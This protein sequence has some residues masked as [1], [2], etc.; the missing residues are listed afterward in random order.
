M[1]PTN[2][3]LDDRFVVEEPIRRGG[4]GIVHRALDRLTG[5]PV[6]IKILHDPND[7]EQVARFAR[8]AS[9]IVGISH[10]AIVRGVASGRDPTGRPYLAMEWLEGEPLDV[11]LRRGPLDASDVVFLGERVATALSVV[12]AH[13][14]VH[15][16]L[17][18][19]NVMLIDGRPDLATLIDFGAA[20]QFE[21]EQAWTESG[22]LVG[23]PSYMAPEQAS[24]A[25][26]VDARADLFSLGCVLF[27]CA[28]GR[29]A[30]TG[31]HVMAILAKILVEEL[32]RL[33]ELRP[34]LPRALDA[35]VARL[36][37]KSADERPSSAEAV[38]RALAAIE[39]GDARASSRRISLLPHAT[40]SVPPPSVASAA[41][42]ASEQRL[43]GVVLVRPLD[44]SRLPAGDPSRRPASATPAPGR[45][46]QDGAA[47]LAAFR[48]SVE[49]AM[50]PTVLREAGAR[51][52]VLAN[53]TVA[54][55]F[56][57]EG[58][59]TDLVRRA[60]ASANAII[61]ASPDAVAALSF[62]RAPFGDRLATGAVI[63]RAAEL[64]SRF[65]RDATPAPSAIRI[66]ELSAALL[67][68]ERGV[69]GRP[70]DEGQEFFFVGAA[71][72]ESPIRTLLGR[73]TPF[74]GRQRELGAVLAA[75]EESA[76]ARRAMAVVLT[77]PAGI[78]K[79]RLRFEVTRVAAGGS[80][81]PTVLLGRGE[82]IG[83]GA[84]LRP[85]AQIVAAAAGIEPK[86]DLR[87]RKRAL[88]ARI[89]GVVPPGERARIGAFLGELVGASEDDTAYPPLRAARRDARWMGEQIRS[90]FIDWLAAETAARPVVLIV[91]D[92]QWADVASVQWLDEALRVLAERPFA[93]FAIGRP[94][95]HE[96]LGRP[97]IDRNLTELRLHELPAA[98][99]RTL[100]H[101]SLGE[102]LPSIEVDRLIE[103]A[104]GNAFYLE[105]LIRE[106]HEAGERGG[107]S[108]PFPATVLAMAQSR[109]ERLPPDARQ[110]LRAASVVGRSFDRG[111]LRLI[112]G[113]EFASKLDGIIDALV[114]REVLTESASRRRADDDARAGELVFRSAMLRDAAYAMLT[115]DDAR[116]AHRAMADALEQDP[117]SDPLVVAEHADLAGQPTRAI[118]SYL[119]A[120]RQALTAGDWEAAFSRAERGIALGASGE[121]L[122]ALR[123]VMA[124]VR[125]FQG[126]LDAL[127]ELAMAA[128]EDLVPGSGD[129]YQAIASM[130]VARAEQNGRHDELEWLISSLHDD[131]R[132][133]TADRLAAV[134]SAAMALMTTGQSS[135][136]LPLIEYARA[137]ADGEAGDPL[138][139]AHVS[140]VEGIAA[141]LIAG[142]LGGFIAAT[143][144]AVAEF[145]AA[146]DGGSLLIALPNLGFGLI[147]VGAF[148]RA[149]STLR[150]AMGDAA[151]MGRNT[152]GAAH[153]LALVLGRLGAFDE[154]VT[155]AR[156]A[157]DDCHRAGHVRL[158]GASRHYLARI[159][160]WRGALDEAAAE[161]ERAMPLLAPFAN[162]RCEALATASEI[163]RR[164]GRHAR[165]LELSSSAMEILE[166]EGGVEDD[167][168]VRA[169]HADALTAAGRTVEADAVMRTAHAA[170][171]RQASLIGDA[172]VRAS[173]LENVPEH[174]RIAAAF[175]GC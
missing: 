134:C 171:M 145:S 77:G 37:A 28:T 79:S 1:S 90:A 152:A 124:H 127:G 147:K 121:R 67:D 25:A 41:I 14:I 69:V 54:L 106:V 129:Y 71:A 45:S 57:G 35:L 174:A 5:G 68:T 89:G 159:L 132:P 47:A 61:G 21:A 80:R 82:P 19:A 166:R 143:E 50:T 139:R 175:V 38:G 158:E 117:H 100:V 76:T 115:D 6:A 85:I 39:A 153:N 22:A 113:D 26:T 126:R 66:D 150:R 160:C 146:G 87:A 13:G 30:F 123:W 165:A 78:G 138:V 108:A 114:R 131:P 141:F 122:G 16:D 15:R 84:P 33:R 172:S 101:A 81:P 91:E 133:P 98:A 168:M 55:T 130:V 99:A 49:R 63:D 118:E 97:W 59:A 34:E 51:L 167:L 70:S 163:A 11:V 92:L 104:C 48:A 83:Q 56:F 155:L 3:V 119:R 40:P 53:G 112:L 173:F 9:M 42:G 94:E 156:G 111:S 31:G 88:H 103:R 65:V 136:A 164:Q 20:R 157:V 17:K 4:A 58:A 125:W 93:L 74:V 73:A 140:E 162:V 18:P 10:E 109:I 135:R 128:L 2:L 169:T 142:D 32:P 29:R 8:E 64:L 161:I 24:S 95:L 107:E 46:Q 86:S 137:H 120:A 52:D 72:N 12:H 62:G 170:L 148:A 96:R 154:A 36:T 144:R 44:R 60:A 23:T 75:L 151:R 27:E 116:A 102:A 43:V 110:L 105:E 7:Q 149:E